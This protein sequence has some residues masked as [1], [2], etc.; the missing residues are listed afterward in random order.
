MPSTPPGTLTRSAGDWRTWSPVQGSRTGQSRSAR[1]NDRSTRSSVKS[2]WLDLAFTDGRQREADQA[3][4]DL[5]A[6]KFPLDE[7]DTN[8]D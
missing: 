8:I 4:A 3:N 2:A 7:S 5:A 6:K 1:R